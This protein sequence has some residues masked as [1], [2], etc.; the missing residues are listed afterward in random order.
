MPIILVIQEVELRR[1]VVGGQLSKKSGR[2][3]S[4]PIKNKLG[5]VAHACYPSY[6]ETINRWMVVQ[7]GPGIKARP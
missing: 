5:P 3:P 4:K 1:L 2:P 7:A 6:M